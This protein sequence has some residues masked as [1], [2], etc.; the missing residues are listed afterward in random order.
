MWKSVAFAGSALE[1]SL[2]V[3]RLREAGIPCV[4]RGGAADSS[5]GGF[6][7]GAVSEGRSV[8]VQEA[9]LERARAVIKADEGGFDEEELARLSEESAREALGEDPPPAGAGG[10]APPQPSGPAVLPAPSETPVADPGE[11]GSADP[12]GAPGPAPPAKHGLLAAL[13]KLAHK[14]GPDAPGD[15]FGR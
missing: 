3:G 2:I 4:Q 10:G 5:P 9:D 15:P 6:N 11:D 8:Y 7:R 13:A 1:A 14:T 12:P